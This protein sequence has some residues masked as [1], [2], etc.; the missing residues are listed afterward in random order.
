MLFWYCMIFISLYFI[1]FLLISICVVVLRVYCIVLLLVVV[2]LVVFNFVFRI[3]L[4]SYDLLCPNCHC[5]CLRCLNCLF[6]WL[7]IFSAEGFVDSIHHFGGVFVEDLQISLNCNNKR[8][9]IC[10]FLIDVL[11]DS[12]YRV[13]S[14]VYS[15]K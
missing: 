13:H 7:L 8:G 2:L 9:R 11:I 5:F 6:N 4:S 3:C 15:G 10:F 1:V 12:F 14:R